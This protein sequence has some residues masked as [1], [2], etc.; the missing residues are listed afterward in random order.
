M[1]VAAQTTIQCDQEVIVQADDWL[2]KIA[3]KTYG[4]V[5]AYPAIAE[6][7]NRKHADDN[8][9]AMIENVDLIE[10]GWKLCLPDAVAA[11]EILNRPL[12]LVEVTPDAIEPRDAVVGRL[13]LATTTSTYDSGLLTE[14]LPDFEALYG[15]T[16]EV[17]AV[18]TGQALQLGQNGDADVILVHAREREE[19][20]IEAGFGINRQ[21]VM[22][23]DFVIVGPASDPAQIQGSTDVSSALTAIVK[24]AHNFVSRG[25]DSGTHSKEQALWRTTTISLIEEDGL[26]EGTLQVKPDGDWYLSIGQ[27]MGATLTIANEQQAY[28]LTDRAT[29]LSRKLEGLD[30][31]IMVEG[32]SRLF[33]PYGVIAINPVQHDTVNSEGADYFITWLTALETQQQISEYG[34]DT[35]GQPL[36]TPDSTAW[37]AAQQ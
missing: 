21:D 2:S 18:G 33:N 1:P 19:A 15:A 24:A 35:F 34:T 26:K 14:I 27:G 28:T 20:F 17:I 22:Y 12:Q 3:D 23:N 5:F 30:L 13:V 31:E 32:D 25:D 11:A 9:F 8:S 29:F 36:F 4:D 37:N 10:I 16:V 7:T 6:A